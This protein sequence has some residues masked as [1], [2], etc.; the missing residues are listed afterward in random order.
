MKRKANDAFI[1][2]PS[3]RFRVEQDVAAFDLETLQGWVHGMIDGI[4]FPAFHARGYVN[5]D[6]LF[7]GSAPNLLATELWHYANF[8][9]LPDGMLHGDVVIIGGLNGNEDTGLTREEGSPRE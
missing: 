9:W 7:D 5:G 4:S 6:S 2:E 8:F 3:G 1:I